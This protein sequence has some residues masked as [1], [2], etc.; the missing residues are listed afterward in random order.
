[1]SQQQQPE[2]TPKHQQLMNF[3]EELVTT[4]VTPEVLARGNQ[5]LDA[6][7]LECKQQQNSL[8]QQQESANNG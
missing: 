6:A 3:L 2:L 7:A 1:M 8:R 4:P 5:L